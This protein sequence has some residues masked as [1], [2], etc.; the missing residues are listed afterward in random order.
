MCYWPPLSRLPGSSPGH[1][2]WICSSPP[3]RSPIT[4]LSTPATPR[5]CA[6][7]TGQAGIPELAPR[8]PVEYYQ[9]QGT[10]LLPLDPPTVPQ[11]RALVALDRAFPR[12]HTRDPGAALAGSHGRAARPNPGTGTPTQ[13]PP[14]ARRPDRHRPDRVRHPAWHRDLR[15]A[16]S[17]AALLS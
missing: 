9:P 10:S 13:G 6:V 15:S 3:P 5:T 14:H 4:P 16:F 2:S 17:D 12:L 7:W 1:V 8:L 11:P